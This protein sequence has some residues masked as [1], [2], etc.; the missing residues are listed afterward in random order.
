[1]SESIT[2]HR[3]SKAG[4]EVATT[5]F[6]AEGHLP[7][8]ACPTYGHA[9]EEAPVEDIDDDTDENIEINAMENKTSLPSQDWLRVRRRREKPCVP[10]PFLS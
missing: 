7:L 5:G 6:C 8:E 9:L 1:M 3:C 10:L 2:E 4:C